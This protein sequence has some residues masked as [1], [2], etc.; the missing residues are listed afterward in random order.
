MFHDP[1]LHTPCNQSFICK[2]RSRR[3]GPTTYV[4]L[5]ETFSF[6]ATEA[7]PLDS[8][9]PF[10]AA[11][12]HSQESLF[13]AFSDNSS[14]PCTPHNEM[15]ESPSLALDTTQY[16]DFGAASSPYSSMPSTPQ[17]YS[18]SHAHLLGGA[19]VPVMHP[20]DSFS[21]SFDF[22]SNMSYPCG[23]QPMSDPYVA[24]DFS[25]APK[26]DFSSYY[27]RADLASYHAGAPQTYLSPIPTYGL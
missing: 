6:N 16:S 21:T 8:C 15:F 14:A 24:Q 25:T 13:D 2:F 5:Q 11:A 22:F 18:N 23:F 3:C 17:D 20:A 7:S 10:T 9:D 12:N 4:L 1:G 27:D 19:E 26:S